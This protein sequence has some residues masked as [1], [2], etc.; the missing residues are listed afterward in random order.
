MRAKPSR[1]F[2]YARYNAD[3]S[4][5]GLDALG[6]SKMDPKKV[7]QFD[8]VDQVDNLLEIGFSAGKKIKLEH[9][10]AFAGRAGTA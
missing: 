6:C 2:V 10:G 9:L 1:P 5:E 4:A 8:A 3:L 7:Q